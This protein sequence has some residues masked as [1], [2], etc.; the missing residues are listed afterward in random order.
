MNDKGKNSAKKVNQKFK[1]TKRNISV[2]S[3]EQM[4][5]LENYINERMEQVELDA[6]EKEQKSWLEAEKT[7]VG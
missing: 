5:K 2:L 1:P 3:D 6:T 4:D 7:I